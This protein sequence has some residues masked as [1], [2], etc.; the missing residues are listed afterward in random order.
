VVGGAGPAEPSDVRLC[1]SVIASVIAQGADPAQIPLDRLIAAVAAAQ[2]GAVTW[3]QLVTLGVA[4]G[5]I[6]SRVRRGLLHP[7]HRGVYLWGQPSPTPLARAQAAVLACGEG[8]VLSHQSAAVRWG[9][10]PPRRG[11]IEVTVVG[12]RVGPRGIRTH[13]TASLHEADIRRL[14]GIPITS[15]ARTLLD[16]ASKLSTRDLA[17]ALEQAQVK[18]L[19]TKAHIVGAL[20][21]APRRPGTRALRA[22][23]AEPAFTR[24]EAE[25]RLLA[26]L[27][28]AKLPR[29]VFNHTVESYE[30]DVL[31]RA[32]RVVLEF[33]SYAFHATRAAFERDRERDAALARGGY[34][35][36]RTTWHELHAESHALIAR[37]AEA[38]ARPRRS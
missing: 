4:R 35:S 19:V 34:V 22:L 16:I 2:Q 10:R 3:R 27:R 8:A 37:V 11:P 23:I 14:H 20:N 26:L 15:P 21:R 13:E 31:W 33:D 30:V 29:P 17:S 5:G 18:R 9:I 32:E 25:R 36:L 12:R 7:M 1:R 38:L 6:A 28:C 24:S